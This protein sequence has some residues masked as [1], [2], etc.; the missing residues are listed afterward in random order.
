MVINVHAGHN[1]DGMRACGAIGIIK[2]STEARRIK[3]L[4]IAGLRKMNHVVY[5][6]TCE[7]GLSANDVLTKIVKKCNEHDAELDVSIH[8]NCGAYD[9][10]GNDKTTGVEV[11]IYDYNAGAK[12]YAERTV[13]AIAELG[14]RNRKVKLNKNLYVLRM[15]KAPAMLIECC[16]V[17]DRDDVELYD[18]EKM[19]D[20]IIYGIT[21]IR[22]S[23]PAE[24]EGE[25]SLG[26]T[27]T[28]P[29]KELYRVQVGAYS[30]K[31]NAVKMQEKL[32][33]SGF[34]AIIVKA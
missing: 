29:K 1:P 23:K 28:A 18:C 20:A 21:G 2:E 5:D 27:P 30:I 12:E 14:F 34:A 31:E 24:I 6:C 32:S 17:D 9:P 13:N 19:A 33:K 10:T 11:F 8:L 3:D 15:T 16:F 26:E 4:V 22:P 25:T 7:D